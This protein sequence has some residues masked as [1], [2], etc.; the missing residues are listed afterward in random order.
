MSSIVRFEKKS[1]PA[2]KKPAG[3]KASIKSTH[4]KSARFFSIAG[5]PYVPLTG[6][7]TGCSIQLYL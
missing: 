6:A 5:F 3:A 1:L 4:D 7:T 2:V